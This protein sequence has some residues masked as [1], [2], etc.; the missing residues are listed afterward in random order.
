MSV[1]YFFIRSSNLELVSK[2][3]SV[4]RAYLPQVDVIVSKHASGN[5]GFVD[6]ESPGVNDIVHEKV[7]KYSKKKKNEEMFYCDQTNMMSVLLGYLNEIKSQDT[8]HA[9][10]QLVSRSNFLSM[11]AS[12][13]DLYIKINQEKFI[14]ILSVGDSIDQLKLDDYEKKNNHVFYVSVNQLESLNDYISKKN[15]INLATDFTVDHLQSAMDIAK[16]FGVSSE[17]FNLMNNYKTQLEKSADKSIKT[18]LQKLDNLQGHF[19][20]THSLVIGYLGSEI[21]LNMPWGS[22]ELAHKFYLGALL[23]DTG[24][25]HPDHVFLEAKSSH[26]IKQLKKD[27]AFDIVNHVGQTISVIE[28]AKEIDSDIINLIRYHHSGIG[29]ASYPFVS[30]G[31]EITLVSALFVILHNFML[32]MTKRALNLKKMRPLIDDMPGLYKTGQFKK[33]LPDVQ[34]YLIKLHEANEEKHE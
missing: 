8:I 27:V 13:V 24:F 17:T 30:Y 26:E 33:I 32:E 15:K 14:K 6:L 10:Y 3:K 9:E 2:V 19:I 1:N 34:A 5:Y 18:L 7:V 31:N 11:K 21:I 12:V 22:P 25:T 4:L 23:H 20:Y 28:N 16:T 29:E